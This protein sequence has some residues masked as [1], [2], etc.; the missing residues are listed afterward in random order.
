MAKSAERG[1][2]VRALGW[3]GPASWDN[4]RFGRQGAGATGEAALRRGRRSHPPGGEGAAAT[5]GGKRSASGLARA[6]ILPVSEDTEGYD[7]YICHPRF[8]NEMVRG[9][10]VLAW[11]R[12]RF[13][14]PAEV[15]ILPL[16]DTQ[17]VL[18]EDE[19]WI[20]LADRRQPDLR[21]N[22]ARAILEDSRFLQ[23]QPIRRQ[24]QRTLGRQQ[25]VRQVRVTGM[26]VAGFVLLA[27][28]FTVVAGW[29]VQN[30]VKGIP[31]DK[32]IAFGEETFKKISPDLDFVTDTNALLQL[33]AVAAPLLPSVPVHGIPFQF[34]IIEG[35]PNA[36]AL[37]G[38]RVVVTTGL[39]RLMDTP[40]QLAGVLAHESAHVARR[41]AFQHIISGKG[42][43]FIM[44][45][46]AGGKNQFFNIMA[47]PSELLVYESFS[48]KYERE[49]DS[50]G[51]DY[52]VAAGI[53]PHGM[54]EALQKLRD[55]EGDGGFSRGKAFA[56][57]PDLDLRIKWL[58]A[59][60]EALPDKTHFITLTNPV[61]KVAGEQRHSAIEDLIK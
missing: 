26:A 24:L 42:P 33:Q 2:R 14:S 59:K 60:W 20:E 5:G 3:Q 56:S 13:D 43:L 32:E 46:L 45:L 11:D 53:N 58:K 50:Y 31:A 7:A 17:V 21:F 8:G 9:R 40:E 38:G 30:I 52:L 55:F 41:H 57:H 48:Q 15:F 16:T 47:I 39:L 4:S 44:E 25:V 36:F 29:A 37:P 23:A 61:P 35:S 6:Y 12:L 10:F 28:L 22:V 1:V 49:A 34:Y 27:W 19:D 54:I 18:G 51:W